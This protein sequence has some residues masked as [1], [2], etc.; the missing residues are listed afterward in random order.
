MGITRSKIIL[1]ALFFYKTIYESLSS[2]CCWGLNS[3]YLFGSNLEL[4]CNHREM[5]DAQMVDVGFLCCQGRRIIL[6][7]PDATNWWRK[8]CK[9]VD[10]S[11]PIKPLL[12]LDYLKHSKVISRCSILSSFQPPTCWFLSR[13]TKTLWLVCELIPLGKLSFVVA[14]WV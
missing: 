3:C 4:S 11:S 14:K 8:N 6:S 5:I 9:Y 7:H 13:S 10:H 1:F 12:S 2:L